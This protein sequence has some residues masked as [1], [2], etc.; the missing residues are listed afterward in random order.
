VAIG[1]NHHLSRSARPAYNSNFNFRSYP[2]PRA[3]L[4]PHRRPSRSRSRSSSGRWTCARFRS[5]KSK[6]SI[7]FTPDRGHRLAVRL[8]PRKKFG[9]SLTLRWREQDSNREFLLKPRHECVQ[10]RPSGGR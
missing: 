7:E 5:W 8:C 2:F 4:L 1:R 3:A 9:S 10:A 6:T